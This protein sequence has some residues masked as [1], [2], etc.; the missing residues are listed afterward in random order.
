ME[1]FV[2][3]FNQGK[4]FDAHEHLEE[5]WLELEGQD[6]AWT[7]GLIQIA[8][9]MHLISLDRWAGAKKVYDRAAKNLAGA[10]AQF[11]GIKLELLWSQITNIV[12][13]QLQKADADV[14]IAFDQ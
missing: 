12:Q 2:E 3:L 7:Q 1:R 14:K 5:I 4:Y 6:K 9:L 8:A 10:P 11:N 13:N